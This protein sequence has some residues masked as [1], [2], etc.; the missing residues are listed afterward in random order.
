MPQDPVKDSMQ[1]TDT[2]PLTTNFIPDPSLMPPQGDAYKAVFD[3]LTQMQNQPVYQAP[4]E[5]N[6]Q[7]ILNALAQG[8]AILASP[9]SGGTLAN[10]LNQRAQIQQNNINAERAKQGQISQAMIQTALD[11]ARSI[12]GEQQS[13][14]EEARKFA[15]KGPEAQLAIETQ[16]A[17]DLNKLDLAQKEAIQNNDL[18]NRFSLDV[19]N[20]AKREAMAK[21]APELFGKGIELQSLYQTFVPE[22]PRAIAESLARKQSGQEPPNYSEVENEWYNKFVTAR[23]EDWKKDKELARRVK[24]AE[25]TEKEAMSQYY[26][27]SK[28]QDRYM[29]AFQTNLGNNL[30][31]SIDSQYFQAKDGKIYSDK[32][33]KAMPQLQQ[34]TLMPFTPLSPE[35]SMQ[36][37]MKNIN[38]QKS[39]QDSVKNQVNP[40][41]PGQP[42]Q[43]NPSGGTNTIDD[44]RQ[45]YID[46]QAK[47]RTPDQIK[48]ILERNGASPEII[49]TIMQGTSNPTPTQ[50]G[51]IN[52]NKIRQ[53][54]EKLRII[55]NKNPADKD[56]KQ[57]YEYAKVVLAE[58]ERKAG[59]K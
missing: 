46:A 33:I 54:V 39:L 32:Q 5:G 44:F 37:A 58:A 51:P 53:D 17:I 26:K 20:R 4:R 8:G 59:I 22:M 9:D 10:I 12:T 16:K 23:S 50:E 42:T 40:A 27:N 21:A 6:L 25:I 19:A 3:L 48:I 30:A 41:M 1:I 52:I 36:E 7:I 11:K 13:S 14:R 57:R 35:E 56:A 18:A 29:N 31:D 2:L 15:Y 28:L 24:E 47:G 55:V 34:L 38:K 45:I 49:S 43:G